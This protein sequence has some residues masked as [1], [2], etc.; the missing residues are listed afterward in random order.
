ME[1]IKVG[2]REAKMHLSRYLKTVQSG[3][4]VIITDRG[5]PIGKIV[6]LQEEEMPLAERLRHLEHKGIIE[7]KRGRTGL[8][9]HTPVAVEHDIAQKY[10]QKDRDAGY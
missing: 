10:L 4:E 1:R 7:P 2:V 5:R 3:G 6:P 8:K 9:S